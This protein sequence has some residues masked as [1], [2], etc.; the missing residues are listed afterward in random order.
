MDFANPTDLNWRM[1]WN[2][3]DNGG[4]QRAGATGTPRVMHLELHTSDR[5]A[6]SVFYADLVG[7]RTEPI[8]NRSGTYHALLLGG[9]LDAGMVECGTAR[10]GWLAYVEVDD[11]EA[12]TEL[13]RALGTSVL[14]SPREG[15]AGWRSVVHTPA[16]GEIALWQ[17]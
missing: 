7:W 1:R 3:L 9:G 16:G 8:E 5:E 10:P 6:A 14:L 2:A 17:Q 11:I 4:S 15:A 12:A 13:A